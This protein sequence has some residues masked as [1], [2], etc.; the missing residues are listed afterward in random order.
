MFSIINSILA[1]TLKFSVKTIPLSHIGTTMSSKERRFV[2]ISEK[3]SRVFIWFRSVDIL[4]LK[5]IKLVFATLCSV[6]SLKFPMKFKT[7]RTTQAGSVRL[8]E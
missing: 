4:V 5:C 3:L 8:I 7:P 2:P 1:S 6:F